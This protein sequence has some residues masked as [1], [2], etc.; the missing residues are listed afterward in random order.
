M[1]V[2]KVGVM[3][4]GF[5]GTRS[6]TFSIFSKRSMAQKNE[7]GPEVPN[8]WRELG[9]GVEVGIW[10]LHLSPLHHHCRCPQILSAG[11]AGAPDDL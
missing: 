5:L 8:R 11:T 4:Y 10:G 9:T 7:Q 2:L 1:G 3:M 6:L